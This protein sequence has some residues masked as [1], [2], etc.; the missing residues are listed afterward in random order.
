MLNAASLIAMFVVGGVILIAFALWEVRW[1]SHYALII[2]A[3]S[4]RCPIAVRHRPPDHAETHLEP[5]LRQFRDSPSLHLRT[6]LISLPYETL[7]C[8]S[9]VS[10][11]MPSAPSQQAS[12]RHTFPPGSTVC[13]ILH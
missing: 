7:L 13:S 11:S 2:V 8:R 3:F 6:V 10:S 1:W 12:A 9:C 4:Y 5:Y